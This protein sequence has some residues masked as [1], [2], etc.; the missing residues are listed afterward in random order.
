MKY[1]MC[2]SKSYQ[3]HDNITKIAYRTFSNHLQMSLIGLFSHY[4]KSNGKISHFIQYIHMIILNK[5]KIILGNFI[6]Y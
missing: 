5:V 3:L 6:N 1:F 4:I 2:L